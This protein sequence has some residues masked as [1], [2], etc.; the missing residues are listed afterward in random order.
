MDSELDNYYLDSETYIQQ[1]FSKS[2]IK[3]LA[4][5]DFSSSR[6]FIISHIL[7]FAYEVVLYHRNRDNSFL[8]GKEI[9]TFSKLLKVYA[10]IMQEHINETDK[11]LLEREPILKDFIKTHNLNDSDIERAK[12]E[13]ENL[14]IKE[15]MT[16]AIKDKKYLYKEDGLNY[17]DLE[18]LEVYKLAYGSYR[19]LYVKNEIDKS[20]I[21]ESANFTFNTDGDRKKANR[22]VIIAV[23]EIK[24]FLSTPSQE[25][26]AVNLSKNDTLTHLNGKKTATNIFNLVM[27]YQKDLNPKNPNDLVIIS[28]LANILN[29]SDKE[30]GYLR[31]KQ[32]N[33]TENSQEFKEIESQK[34]EI[35][36]KRAIATRNYIYYEGVFSVFNIDG[37]NAYMDKDNRY[38][39]KYINEDGT[40]TPYARIFPRIWR[41]RSPYFFKIL[42]L[43]WTYATKKGMFFTITYEDI[44]TTFNIENREFNNAVVEIKKALEQLSDTRFID[45]TESNLIMYRPLDND[46]GWAI[47]F[48]EGLYRYILKEGYG[49]LI[50]PSLFNMGLTDRQVKLYVGI[51]QHIYMNRNSHPNTFN[52]KFTKNMLLKM[53]GYATD[54]DLNSEIA[55]K[56]ALKNRKNKEYQ[57]L[58]KDLKAICF[59]NSLQ[60]L[61]TADLVNELLLSSNLDGNPKNFTIMDFYLNDKNDLINEF[62]RLCNANETAY[63]K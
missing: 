12:S 7:I 1:I 13:I 52:Y 22:L 47:Q 32:I 60:T 4:S 27:G 2:F 45:K 40:E 18:P 62:T 38:L 15:L 59:N 34:A 43:L 39:I 30:I 49:N 56:K 25:I 41:E 37:F 24:N 31:N 9:K 48:N 21:K 20:D 55:D 54:T 16:I 36:E 6:D 17:N 57:K 19:F 33:L 8:D 10:D 14:N 35:Y 58:I 5:A 63:K 61:K 11:T 26:K 29:E 51:T 50:N 3:R 53:G 23:S 44:K 46:R 42:I 28:E